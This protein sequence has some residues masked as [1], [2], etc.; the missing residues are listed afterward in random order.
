M[1]LGNKFHLKQNKKL[2]FS[3]CIIILF[4][5]CR[6]L[7]HE[8]L[9]LHEITNFNI[10]DNINLQEEE[11]HVNNIKDFQVKVIKGDRLIDILEK[12][13]V[14]K[15]DIYD[16]LSSLKTK[17]NINKIRTGQMIGLTIDN[18]EK[19]KLINFEIDIDPI[20][21][22]ISTH[23]DHGKFESKIIEN[24]Q[25]KKNIRISQPI[26]DSLFSTATSNGMPDSLVMNLAYLYNEDLNLNRDIKDGDQFDVIFEQFIDE[27]GI[28]SHYGNIIYSSLITNKGEK[29]NIYRYTKKNGLE[30]YFHE[31]GKYVKSKHYLSGMPLSEI[32]I[33][34][35]FGKRYHPIFKKMI[36]HKGVDFVANIGTPVKSTGD[37]VIEYVG[38]RG[39]YG[40]YIRI[41]H[42]KNYSTAYA[43][44]NKFK[45]GLKVGSVVQ[46][47]EIIAYSGKTGNVTGPHLHYEVLYNNKHIDP[48]KV[49][50]FT[51]NTS[52]EGTELEEFKKFT[53][54]IQV[55]LKSNDKILNIA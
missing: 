52:L 34:S 8:K 26:K 50:F 35:T 16:L 37:G 15:N 7:Y 28:I 21:K 14:S 9:I 3:S 6:G 11:K 48:M 30:G 40:K 13:K 29:F 47:G 43:H 51:P 33:S 31:N 45:Y 27:K 23:N 10:D 20:R 5:F 2:F 42:N 44:L 39:G 18:S 4:L 1:L 46:L 12:Y 41:K 24:I 55:S 53:K 54:K 32:K 38:N 17:Y 49:E 25:F 36:Y 19:P 22:I